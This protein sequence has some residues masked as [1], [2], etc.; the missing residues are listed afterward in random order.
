VASAL[1]ERFG[2]EVPFLGGVPMDPQ[3]RAGGDSGIPLVLSPDPPALIAVGI[4]GGFS[5]ADCGAR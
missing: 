5:G 3:V 2:Y 4:S 1:G